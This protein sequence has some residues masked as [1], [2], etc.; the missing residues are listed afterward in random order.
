MENKETRI[1]RLEEN[2][3]HGKVNNARQ[4]NTRF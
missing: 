1:S 4:I 3:L 2:I